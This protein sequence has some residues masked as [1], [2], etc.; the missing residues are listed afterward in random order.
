MP[1]ASCEVWIDGV[2]AADEPTAYLA[3][4]P[5]VLAPLTVAWGRSNVLDQPDTATC[6]F[7]LQRRSTDPAGRVAAM[8]SVFDTVRIGAEVDVY[9]E[10]ATGGDTTQTETV[11]DGAFA[12]SP[13]PGYRVLTK[14]VNSYDTWWDWEWF[15]KADA[16]AQRVAETYA[17]AAGAQLLPTSSQNNW[18]LMVPPRAFSLVPTAWDDLP[19]IDPTEV[20]SWEWSIDVRGPAGAQIWVQPIAFA[21]PAPPMGTAEYPNPKVIPGLEVVRTANG[22]WATLTGTMDPSRL[23]EQAG[24]WIGLQITCIR[25]WNDPWSRQAWEDGIGT[26]AD[27]RPGV[28][29]RDDLVAEVDNVS[30]VAPE[31]ART[32]ALVFSG[33]VTDLSAAYVD[34]ATTVEVTAADISADLANVVVGDNPW[35]VERADARMKRIVALTP[36][37][38]RP[39]WPQGWTQWAAQSI[40]WRDVDAQPVWGLLQD[41]AQSTGLVLW[42][43]TH[44]SRGPYLYPENPEDRVPLNVW[45]D[46]GGQATVTSN[47][48]TVPLSACD[49]LRD[50]VVWGQSVSDAVTRVDVT[51]QEQT[52]DDEGQPAPTERHVLRVD[53]AAE[54]LYGQRRLGVGTELAAEPDAIDLADDLMRYSTTVGWALAGVT[55]DTSRDPVGLPSL[56]PEQ[57][58]AALLALLGG[59]SRLGL[60]LLLMDLPAGAPYSPALAAYVEGGKYTFDQTWALELNLSPGAYQGSE[61]F[62]GWAQMLPDWSWSDVDP[63]VSWNEGWAAPPG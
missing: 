16:H 25:Q 39:V 23:S 22:E 60:P 63:A 31:S 38:V 56:T 54:A 29:W 48:A 51:W 10:G 55:L 36:E 62:A 6:T 28:T 15:T 47:G 11:S 1:S 58:Q 20:A 42:A 9:S 3:G 34:S 57:R 4:Q 61:R 50:P 37:S 5:T 52:T 8:S 33:R 14:L 59:V 49:V 26:W 32:R 45:A 21:S 19:Q 43:A 2:R 30:I 53:A 44:I 24:A 40:G 12:T 18:W 46:N 7:A 35:P 27:Y 17:H 41:V 13:Q